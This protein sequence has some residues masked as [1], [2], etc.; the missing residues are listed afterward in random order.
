MTANL[1][2]TLVLAASVLLMTAVQAKDTRIVNFPAP[3]VD[4]DAMAAFLVEFDEMPALTMTTTRQGTDNKTAQ[5][6]TLFF[7]NY[8]TKSWSLVEKLETG[9]F[10]ITG[11]GENVTPYVKKER[12]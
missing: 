3:C 11:A 7:I 10:C 6:Q 2:K 1:F 5:H 9:E 8:K 4:A 12:K